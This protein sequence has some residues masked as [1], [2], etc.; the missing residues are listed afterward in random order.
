MAKLRHLA[1]HTGNPVGTA[2]FYK[3]VFDMK[4]LRRTESPMA[5]GIHL[6]DGWLH[7]ALLRYR[8]PELA[9]TYGSSSALGMSHIGFWLDEADAQEMRRKLREA[10][11]VKGEGP[12]VATPG[13]FFEE[14]W[15]GPDGVVFD[16]SD[17]KIG[18]AH[19]QAKIDEG[20]CPP[21]IRHLA[22]HT[23][24]L[25]ATADFYKR[26]FDMAEVGRNTTA[27]SEGI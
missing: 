5:E 6:S 19:Y 10:G 7:L 20:G 27:V 22:L 26:V 1:L 4:E 17:V 24:D 12:G 13:V 21:K 15:R 2:D 16:L 18:R 11:A 3:R 14:K 9:A 23:A 8:S 25:E